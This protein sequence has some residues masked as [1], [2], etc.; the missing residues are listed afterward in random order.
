[1]KTIVVFSGAGLSQESGIPTFRDSKT[2]L[3]E[4]HKIEDVASQEG[5]QNN[6]QL[7]LDFYKARYENCS[8]VEPNAAHLAIA[9]LEKKYRVINITQNVD[10]LLERAGCTQVWHLHGDLY[11]R[12]CEWHK[13]ISNLDGDTQFTC[14]FKII[15]DKPVELGE[16]CPKCNGQL[17]PDVVWFGEA[18]DMRDKEL[19][20]LMN[21]TYAFIGC[22]TSAQVHPAASLLP[23]FNYLPKERKF[24]IDKSPMLRLQS[25]TTIQGSASEKLPELVD[26]LLKR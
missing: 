21:N 1:M 14:D 2:G 3:W 17:R 6:K 25:W 10:N 4:N 23:T 20:G 16:K 18:V 8:K 19:F 15:Q 26:D 12:K 13:D 5:W 24:F 22:G 9:A 11:H 7:V